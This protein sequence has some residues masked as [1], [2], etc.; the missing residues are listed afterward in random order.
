MSKKF[1][2]V[3]G[4]AAGASAAAR[5]RRLD[6]DA[7]IVI[8]E[9]DEHVSFSNCGLPYFL[10]GKIPTKEA[11]VLMN[12]TIFKKQYNIDART[13]SEALSIDRKN[14]KVRVKSL[15]RG[16]YEES[17]DFLIL[18]PG[19]DTIIPDIPGLDTIPHFVVKNVTGTAALHEYI[20]K[21]ENNVKNITVIGAGFIGLEVME[22]LK[23][24]GYNLTLIEFRNEILPLVDHDMAQILH[25]ELMDKE[26]TL[27]LGDT[28]KNIAN[29]TLELASGKKITADAVILATGIRPAVSFAEKSG[30]EISDF[31]AIKVNSNGQTND[32]HIYAAGD[33]VEVY[34]R[35]LHKKVLF[36]LAGPAQ[37][38]ARNI[39][40]HIYKR[41]VN[42]RGVI[43]SFCIQLFD[44]NIACTGMTE[45]VIKKELPAL[46]YTVVKIIP[47][48]RI[49]IMPSASPLHFKLIFE[50][51]SGKVLGAQAIGRGDTTKRIDIIATLIK[52][53]GTI[54][55]LQDLE[56][57]Y[58]PPFSTAKDSTNMA[59]YVGTNLLLNEYR[60]VD[61]A[62]VRKLL[63]QGHTI[64]DVREKHEYDRGHIKGAKNIP[65][66]ELRQRLDEFPVDRPVYV[67]CRSGQR[68]YNATRVL[69]HHGIDAYNIAA[70]FLGLSFYEYY[71]DKTEQRDP[72]V[73]HYNFN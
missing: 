59:G 21:P 49:G 36:P 48:D 11:L 46:D 3:G 29:G 56:L 72:I 23:L 69:N 41:P 10:S 19:A 73:T 33:A 70:G 42:N 45:V 71:T 63:N 26:V 67:H 24:A 25:K 2:I 20:T 5:L 54:Y 57:T 34:S 30:I 61:C 58:S 9:R 64:V 27:I 38:F 28:V 68:S 53:D 60:Q 66:S 14:K 7:K 39:A 8:F 40:N 51:P 22:N 50:N 35:I 31:G 1:I 17:Y 37:K 4:V 62:Q 47:H 18:A 6:E 55:D 52:L 13:N 16:E 65:L 43:H 15:D 12:P 32:P 44:Y